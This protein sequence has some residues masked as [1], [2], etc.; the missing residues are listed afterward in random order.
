MSVIWDQMNISIVLFATEEMKQTVFWCWISTK[1]TFPSFTFIHPAVYLGRS[2][3]RLIKTTLPTTLKCTPAPPGDP[4]V[5]PGQM[6]IP[7]VYSGFNPPMRRHP[8]QMPKQPL[9]TPFNVKEQPLHS[10]FP[11]DLWS[12]PNTQRSKLISVHL[13]PPSHSFGRHPKPVSQLW[14]KI[15]CYFQSSACLLR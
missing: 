4:K 1:I 2:G 12:P 9:L 3:S 6:I 11:I 8:N 15:D 14:N 7:P 5:F 10:E 13:Y